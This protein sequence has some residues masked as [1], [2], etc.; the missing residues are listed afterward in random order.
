MSA[1]PIRHHGVLLKDRH[2][3][4]SDLLLIDLC[5]INYE[6]KLSGN[7]FSYIY[8]ALCRPCHGRQRGRGCNLGIC[9]LP[10]PHLADYRK[11]I[12][13]EKRR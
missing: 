1:F 11:E 8:I 9:P 4:A 2:N 13:T 12:R 3:F 7:I 6:H 5:L 10:T